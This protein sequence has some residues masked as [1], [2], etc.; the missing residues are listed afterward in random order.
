MSFSNVEPDTQQYS[1]QFEIKKAATLRLEEL[2]A[3]A[4]QNGTDTEKYLG[5]A[6]SL[7]M[8]LSFINSDI[9][10]ACPTEYDILGVFAKAYTTHVEETVG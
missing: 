8:D 2:F 9:V 5:A 10:D 7:L 4:R 1:L 6:T 3:Q